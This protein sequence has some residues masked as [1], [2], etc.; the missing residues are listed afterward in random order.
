MSPRRAAPGPQLSTGRLRVDAA[1]AIAKLREYQLADRT[2]WVLEAIRAAVAA[3]ATR[4]ELSADA[5]DVWLAWHGEP[6]PDAVLPALFDELVS[7]EAASGRHH[8]RLLAAAVNSALGM[9]PSY[10][11][12]TAIHAGTAKRVRYTPEILVEPASALGDAAL[13]HVAVETV[14]PP[15]HAQPG[16]HV[17]LRRR[18]GDWR[19]LSEAPELALARAACREIAVPLDVGGTVLHRDAGADVVRI[20][21]GEGLDGFIAI[22]EPQRA[23]GSAILEVAE[24]GVVLAEYP[25]QLFDDL[26]GSARGPVPCRVFIDAPRMPTNASRSQVRRDVHP[27]T[28]AERRAEKLVPEL[29]AQL[30]TAVQQGSERARASALALLAAYAGGSRWHVDLPAVRGPLRELAGLPLVKNAVGGPRSLTEHWRA[31]VHTGSRPYDAELAPWLDS[32]LWAPPDDPSRQLLRGVE[33]DTRGTRRFVRWARKQLRAQKRFYAHAKREARVQTSATPH[34]RAS[35]G[36]SAAK[37]AV[38]DDMFARLEGEVCIYRDGSL[39]ALAVLLEGRELERIEFDSPLAFDVVIESASVTPAERYRGVKRDAEYKRVERAMRGGL[40]RALEAHVLHGRDGLDDE[41]A[42]ADARLVRKGFGVMKELGL[43]VTGPLATATIFRTVDGAWTSLAELAKLDV[44][45]VAAPERR[46]AVPRGRIVVELDPQ[47]ATALAPLV[48]GRIVRYGRDRAGDIDALAAKMAAQAGCALV[49]RENRL[50]AVVAPAWR[51]ELRLYHLGVELDER[52]FKSKWLPCAMAIDSDDIVPGESWST[53]ADDA[54]LSRRDHAGRELALV[55]AIAS[56]FAGEPPP[57]L[58][59]TSPVTLASKLG[60]ALCAAIEKHDVAELLGSELVAKLRA[61]PLVRVLGSD[62][63][64]SI[65]E[66]VAPFSDAVPY[67]A[68]ATEPVAGFAPIIASPAIAHALCKLA[69]REASD[70]TA[71]LQHHRR[72]ALR[73]R[74]LA[75]HRATKPRPMMVPSEHHVDFSFEHARG[76]VGVWQGVFEIRVSVEGRPFAVIHPPDQELPLVAV[77]EVAAVDCD[78]EFAGLRAKV[79]R[80]VAIAVRAAGR[81]LLAAIARKQPQL[82]GDDGPVRTLLAKLPVT[83]DDTRQAL[84]AAPAFRTIQGGRVSLAQ[85]GE[86]HQV[87]SI[88]SWQGEWLGA[89]DE[90]SHAYDE[91]VLFVPEPR[92]ELAHVIEKLHGEGVVDVTPEVSRLQARRR[93]ARGLVPEPRVRTAQ[94]QL[95][96]SLASFGALTKRFVHG[97]IGLAE[98]ASSQVLVHEQGSFVRADALDVLPSVELAIEDADLQAARESAQELAVELTERV[99]AELDPAALSPRVQRNLV[100]AALAKRLPGKLVERVPLWRD[101][102]AQHERFGDVWMVW[103]PTQLTPLDETRRVFFLDRADYEL[104]REHG[105]DVV[106]ARKALELD[107]LARL[108]RART[109]AAALE[110]PRTIGVLA[111]ELLAGDGETSPRGIVAVLAPAAAKDR[112]VWPHRA[113]HPFDRVE[114]PCRWPT[115]AVI[116]DARLAPDRTWT[117]PAPN[118]DWQAVCKEIRAASERALANVGEVPEHAL[119][120]MRVTNHTCAEIKALRKSPKAIVRGVVWLTGVPHDRVAV[121]VIHDGG[122]RSIVPAGQ[123]AIGGKVVVYAPDS[124][125]LALAIDQLCTRAHGKLVRALL[126]KD[127]LDPDLVAAHA[128]HAIAMHTLRATDARTLHVPCFAPRPLDARSLSSLFRRRDP[129]TVIRPGTPPNPD[130]DV[131]EV[132]DDGSELARTVIADLGDRARRARPAPKKPRPAP[133]A[134]PRPVATAPAPARR[135]PP[136]PPHP[137]Q[138]LVAKLRSRLADLGIGGYEWHIEDRD[139]PMFA[140]DDGIIVAGD[141]VRLRALAVA[142]AAKSP[143]AEAGVDVVVAHLVTVLNVALSQVT[144]ASELHALGVLLSQRSAN[145]RRS[146]RSS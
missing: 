121:Q 144:D 38:H 139:D 80:A 54:G 30:A 67:L 77:A 125:D 116:D 142:L 90:P 108:N 146:R 1:R 83:G 31:E 100:R 127:E 84:L 37:S 82:L 136:P 21:L 101:F 141:N 122:V 114:D 40:V 119:V 94:A 48:R 44:I 129:V 138:G 79:E 58:V 65:D 24:R 63:A 3:G 73:E 33:V 107:A 128:A 109:P 32:M 35:L 110:L 45:G 43:A 81:R 104:A 46:V 91:P 98:A 55:R 120:S 50:D 41:A 111:E 89:G 78:A 28:S 60:G 134:P 19:I 29:I 20:A 5:N 4:I 59:I 9:S 76:Q 16:M 72:R 57:E 112:G 71:L 143:F 61:A 74:R 26:A 27:I 47:E 66:A 64:C 2:A 96:R 8:V 39:G 69:G 133:E 93:M 7:P 145:Q 95:K 103:E 42:V 6:W 36:C 23:A 18:L 132:V 51:G 12:V 68:A 117:A 105:W 135:A 130:P 62:R 56:A 115:L 22:T 118:E 106:D 15:A 87:V 85:A 86:P 113:M 124:L 17:H 13:R 75:A 14:S 52:L 126:K 88:A 10:V 102:L 131:I 123:L 25:F 140:F 34:L 11:D 70:G 99:L 97:E 137:L 49:M 53:A 92:H